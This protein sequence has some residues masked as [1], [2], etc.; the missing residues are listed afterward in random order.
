MPVAQPFES[1][2]SRSTA[3]GGGDD[4]ACHGDDAGVDDEEPGPGAGQD[5]GG[6]HEGHG[7]TT[8][9]GRAQI[10]REGEVVVG[11]NGDRWRE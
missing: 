6:I 11:M 3:G 1:L 5:S 7:A 8:G 4:D 10:S 9:T 2:T